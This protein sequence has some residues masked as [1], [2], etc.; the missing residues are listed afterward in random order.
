MKKKKK[1]KKKPM[2]NNRPQE[3]TA[4]IGFDLRGDC[5]SFDHETLGH[6]GKVIFVPVDADSLRIIG[7]IPETEK[8]HSLKREMMEQVIHA[9]KQDLVQRG[10]SLVASFE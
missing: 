6:I 10:G 3:F 9:I 5:V 1:K 2:L 7:E 8:Y 4:T